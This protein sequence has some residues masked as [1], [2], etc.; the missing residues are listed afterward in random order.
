MPRATP[1]RVPTYQVQ[2]LSGGVSSSH[3]VWDVLSRDVLTHVTSEGVSIAYKVQGAG[4]AI[5]FVNSTLNTLSVW[6]RATSRLA[7]SRTTVT[8]DLRN[9]GLSSDGGGGLSDYVQ[10]L[11]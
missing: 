4:P 8:Y 10:D 7:N 2:P 9:Q 3:G 11:F 5:T 6:N 1:K